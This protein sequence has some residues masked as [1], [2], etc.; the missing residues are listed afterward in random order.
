MKIAKYIAIRM[1]LAVV[2]LF[3][4]NLLYLYAFWKEDVKQHGDVLEN[5]WGVDI[6]SDAIY[7]GESSNFHIPEGDSI[8][9]RISFTLDSLLPSISIATVD[10]AGLHAGTYLSLVKNIPKEMN[11][12][13]VVITLNYRS[14][15]ANWRYAAFENY[16]AKSELMLSPLFPLVNKF[17]ISLKQYDY[18]T[19]EERNAQMKL[20]WKNEKFTIPNFDYDNVIE[21]D[22]AMAWHTW[23]DVN[24]NLTEEN[25]SLAS[26]YIKNF[27]FNID[28]V[29]NERIDDLNAIVSIA[30]NKDYK[31]I[32]NL[33]GENTIEAEKLVGK[34]LLY[35]MEKNRSLLVNYYTNKGVIMVDNFYQIP[36]SCFVDR[37]WPT[38]H[39]NY[40]GKKIVAESIKKAIE[41]NELH[42]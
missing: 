1:V 5:L 30:N 6:H 10:N 41:T 40:Q 34:E 16:L 38:E 15:S 33:L 7:F 3:A 35:L 19:E 14:F 39:Y 2:F 27:A 20:A 18:K 37:D 24:P 17:L 26:H 31:V 23:L 32:F 28:T 11:L 4:M 25:L 13:F 22:S 42:Y 21:W 29:Y 36:D 9:H 8:K 12:K